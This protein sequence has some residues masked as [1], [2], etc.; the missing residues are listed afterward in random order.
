MEIIATAESP[1]EAAKSKDVFDGTISLSNKGLEHIDC[2]DEIVEIKKLCIENNKV[3]KLEGL[4]KLIHLIELHAEGNCISRIEGLATLRDLRVL[5]L[6]RNKIRKIEG[7]ESL[8]RLET[9]SLSLNYIGRNGVDDVVGVLEAPT[10][11][12]LDLSKNFIADPETLNAVLVK[13]PH[14]KILHLQG[15]RVTGVMASYRKRMVSALRSLQVLDNLPV[16]ESDKKLADAFV[17]GGFEK[18]I[19]ERLKVRAEREEAKFSEYADNENVDS[20]NKMI[21]KGKADI[22]PEV[23]PVSKLAKGYNKPLV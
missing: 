17:E 8:H 14:L 5:D 23:K 2:L 13:L 21:S 16:S 9:L 10:V 1:K 18:E 7:L 19:E 11:R 22:V 4:E 3:S 20:S 15:N 6:S 12:T